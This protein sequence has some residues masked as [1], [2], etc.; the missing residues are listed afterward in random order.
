MLERLPAPAFLPRF[1]HFLKFLAQKVS[2]VGVCSCPLFATT[3]AL[4][5]PFSQWEFL[6]FMCLNAGQKAKWLLRGG[7]GKH[8]EAAETKSWRV[9]VAKTATTTWLC[10]DCHPQKQAESKQT[11][12][13]E[14]EKQKLWGGKSVQAKTAAWLAQIFCTFVKDKFAT[15]EETGTFMSK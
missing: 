15:K 1:L 4:S 9:S 5:G 7:G 11:N 6:S 2:S 12:W 13:C 8:Y 10:V 14:T 3:L